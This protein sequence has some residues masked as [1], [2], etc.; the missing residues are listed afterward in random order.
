MIPSCSLVDKGRGVII[1]VNN[2]Y[3]SLNWM[4]RVGFGIGSRQVHFVGRFAHH[5]FAC[6]RDRNQ[7]FLPAIFINALENAGVLALLVLTFVFGLKARPAPGGASFFRLLLSFEK[8]HRG[9]RLV[10]F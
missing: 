8:A 3:L 5:P 10:G 4:F 1:T 9:P 6:L 2:R 7:R